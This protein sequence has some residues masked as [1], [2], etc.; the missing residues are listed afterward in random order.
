[1]S[2]LPGLRPAAS[3]RI[4]DLVG[5]AGVD[6]SDWANFKGG[7]EKAAMNPKYC[8]E[9]SYVEP[10]KVVVLNLW[11][12]QMQEQGETI[13][14]VV[15]MRSLADA[16][17]HP[18]QA[19][20]AVKMDFA[21]QKAFREGLPV[22]VVICDGQR[23]D[24]TS[25]NT[26]ASKVERRMLDAM[27]WA[28]TDY[29]SETGDCTLT[30]GASPDRFA[31]QFDMIK[32]LPEGAVVKH[33]VATTEYARSSEVRR[34]VLA[35]AMGRCEWCNAQAFSMAD[36]RSFLETHHVLPLSEGGPDN[37][38]NVVALCPNHHREA[39]FGANASDMRRLLRKKLRDMGYN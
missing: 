17:G 35:R 20:R 37:D 21:L 32:D 23:E 18:A 10:G 22:R 11:Y 29:V 30:R 31:D 27:P 36:G 8:Y 39:H 15:N 4:I 16:C 26:K 13:L 6:V 25:K 9:W 7:P 34:R 14:Q 3:C 1:M 38:G 19:K 2:L 33:E 24:I 28:V 5:E 12:E